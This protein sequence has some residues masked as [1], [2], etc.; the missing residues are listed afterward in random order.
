MECY[1]MRHGEA[2]AEAE[3]PRRPLSD[4]GRRQ[5]E[6]VAR[7]AAARGARVAE[8]FHSGK[9]RAAETAAIM[10]RVLGAPAAIRRMQGLAPEDDPFVA[11]AAIESA[12]SVKMWVGHVPHLSRLASLLVAGDE[13]RE[14]VVLAP[15]T[16]VYLVR[17]D[18]RWRIEWTLSPESR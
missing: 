2:V 4:E 13:E 16:L 15:A 9:Q 18:G 1:L 8:I 3:D 11:K 14:V 6:A 12:E 17:T 5:V 10:A 7:A